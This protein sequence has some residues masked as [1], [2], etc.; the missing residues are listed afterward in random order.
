MT[1]EEIKAWLSEPR[2]LFESKVFDRD[3]YIIEM[4]S[5]THGEVQV[6]I[7][8]KTH[9]ETLNDATAIISFIESHTL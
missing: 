2:S 3:G 1:H 7:T 5:L 9:R 4:V 8:R 6:T